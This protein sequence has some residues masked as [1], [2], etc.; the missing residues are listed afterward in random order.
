[1]PEIAKKEAVRVDNP[2]IPYERM[3]ERWEL[4]HDLLGGTLRMRKAGVKWLPQEEAES[5]DAYLVRLKRSILYN[6]LSDTIKKLVAKPFSRA[7]TYSNIPDQL[8]Y[9]IDD[10]DGTKKNLHQLAKELYEDMVKYGKCHIHVD[11]TN[12]GDT[13]ELTLEDERNAGARVYLNR[14]CPSALIGWKIEESVL[15]RIRIKEVE[16]EYTSDYKQ[17]EV[18]YI[19]EIGTDYWKRHRKGE[20]GNYNVVDEGTHTFQLGIPLIT[21][22]SRRCGFMEADP[23][24]E[25]LAWLNLAHWQSDSDQRNILR[26]LR[27]AILFIKGMTKKEKEEPVELGPTQCFKSESETAEMKYVE[28][29]GNGVRAGRED[30]QDLEARMEVA[31]LQPLTKSSAKATATGK[32]I[33][34]GRSNSEAQDWIRALEHGLFVCFYYAGLWHNVDLPDD[35]SFDIYSDFNTTIYDTGDLT[36][37]LNARVRKEI[38]RETFYNELKRRGKLSESVEAED[39]EEKMSEEEPNMADLSALAG[40]D[41]DE[42]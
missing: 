15:E 7:L 27:F 9:L 22:Y 3:S 14:I 33:D 34:E 39:E 23:P 37:L 12:L 18:E 24:L 38:S 30:L 13:S 4:M 40:L 42:D 26:F 41:E 20:D 25:P 1:M 35:I 2:C 36:F 21:I 31:G 10:V 32:V 19:R 29:T 11:F 5:N 16:L 6:A 28:H 17:E 8:E